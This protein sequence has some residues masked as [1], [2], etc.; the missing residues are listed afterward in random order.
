MRNL[1][2]AIMAL[3]TVS[4]SHYADPTKTREETINCTIGSSADLMSKIGLFP[5]FGYNADSTRQ[6]CL[7][8]R[9]N[10]FEVG[11]YSTADSTF[12]A[13]SSFVAFSSKTDLKTTNLFDVISGNFN[14]SINQ[15]GDTVISGTML[16]IDK[17]DST[18]V[19]EFTITIPLKH[20]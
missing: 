13:K 9:M 4:C 20:Q 10:Q 19:P 1:F 17:A 6:V 5:I 12:D 2:F 16:A 11:D 7:G 8:F 15:A 18:D 14:I 3:L